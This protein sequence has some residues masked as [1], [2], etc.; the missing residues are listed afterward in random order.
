MGQRVDQFQALVS[1]QP[2]N[3]LFRFSLAQ[4]LMAEGRH[5]EA[6]PHFRFCAE[7]RAEW[8]MPR[9]LLAKCLLN[10]NL[11]EEARPLLEAALR[12]AV[13]QQHE[14]PEAEVRGLLR[15]LA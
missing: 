4:A 12:L 9:I 5:A 3:E 10:M 15:D 14:A 7:L 11:Q 6:A 13:A 2:M 1:R 8:M